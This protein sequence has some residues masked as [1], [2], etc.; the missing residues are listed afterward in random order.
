MNRLVALF[1]TLFAMTACATWT[2]EDA[3]RLFGEHRDTSIM[4]KQNIEGLLNPRSAVILQ[5]MHE[6]QPGVIEYAFED[7]NAKW[8]TPA[9]AKCRFIVSAEK[10]TGTMIKWRYNGNPNYCT[11]N[12]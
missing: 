9:E 8:F 1:V 3:M 7:K 6:V 10:D 2:H 5:G 11:D 4:R 12:P